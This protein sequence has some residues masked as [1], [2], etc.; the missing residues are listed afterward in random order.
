[1]P[2]N[3]RCAW[4]VGLGDLTVDRL[5]T[6]GLRSLDASFKR[7]CRFT[8]VAHLPYSMNRVMFCSWSSRSRFCKLKI[9]GSGK[10]QQI[11]H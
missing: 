5:Y 4:G 3:V 2:D 11:N 7:L 10:Q 8:G 9:C 1:M 6:S